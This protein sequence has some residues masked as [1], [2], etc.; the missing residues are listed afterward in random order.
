ML[1]VCGGSCVMCD[2][3]CSCGCVCGMC[4]VCNVLWVFCVVC[5]VC[6]DRG[7]YRISERGGGV[8]V[9]TPSPPP[10][11]PPLLMCVWCV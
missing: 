2:V 5:V 4:V 8:R 1:C 6:D 9:L 7:G 3:C 11:D 10:L